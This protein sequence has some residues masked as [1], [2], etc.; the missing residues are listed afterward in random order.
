MTIAKQQK[1]VIQTPS[2]QR[3]KCGN[4]MIKESIFAFHCPK[5]DRLLYC[6]GSGDWEWYKFE[7]EER[8]L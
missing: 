4:L 7:S 1:E 3:C 2:G 5:C 8:N 6:S